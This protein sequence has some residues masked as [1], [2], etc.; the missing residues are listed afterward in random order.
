[1][2]KKYNC[3]AGT[4][5]M[6]CIWLLFPDNYIF[7]TVSVDKHIFIVYKEP[8]KDGYKLFETTSNYSK[9]YDIN[10]NKIIQVNSNKF[11]LG[12]K[13]LT[14]YYSNNPSQLLISSLINFFNPNHIDRTG[15]YRSILSYNPYIPFWNSYDRLCYILLLSQMFIDIYGIQEKK[16]MIMDK[17]TTFAKFIFIKDDHASYVK[18]FEDI[19]QD[20]LWL[21]IK[22]QA[23][24]LTELIHYH[25]Y[26]ELFSYA[27]LAS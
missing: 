18:Y 2:S 1:M 14:N 11:I 5:F 26:C 10:E 12:L 4:Y 8:S 7:Y 6:Y 20:D 17:T 15:D 24:I 16:K 9:P 19:F 13:L 3:I 27:F 23:F 25:Q 21:F 22:L